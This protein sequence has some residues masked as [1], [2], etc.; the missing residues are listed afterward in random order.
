MAGLPLPNS[1]PAPVES[2]TGTIS[3]PFLSWMP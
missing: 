3:R 2:H 1:V